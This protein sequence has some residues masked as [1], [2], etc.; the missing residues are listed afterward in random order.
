MK[1]ENCGN[2]YYSNRDNK[3]VLGCRRYPPLNFPI[4]YNTN[5]V[6]AVLSINEKLWCGE[7]KAKKKAK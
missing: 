6:V 2:C 5:T 4:P 1:E 7:W 3:G